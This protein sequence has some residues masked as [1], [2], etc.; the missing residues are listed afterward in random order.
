[1]VLRQMCRTVFRT[2]AWLN[3]P[4]HSL[5]IQFLHLCSDEGR[6]QVGS[7][8]LFFIFFHGSIPMTPSGQTTDTLC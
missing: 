5:P 4:P 1:M 2:N 7:Y 6:I 8:A 3:V